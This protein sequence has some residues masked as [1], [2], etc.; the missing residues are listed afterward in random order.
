ME[1]QALTVFLIGLLFLFYSLSIKSK[2]LKTNKELEKQKALL[3]SKDRLLT[4]VSEA[5]NE[6]TRNFDFNRAIVNAFG[7]IGKVIDVDRIVL[8]ENKYDDAEGRLFA[9]YKGEWASSGLTAQ[10]DDAI[11]QDVPIYLYPDLIEPLKNKEPMIKNTKDIEPIFRK[12]LMEHSVYSIML[13]P[14]HIGDFF[15]GYVGFDDCKSERSWSESEKSILLSFAASIAGVIERNEKQQKLQESLSLIREKD[16]L[17]ELIMESTENGYILFGEQG[18]IILTNNM[19]F[20]MFDLPKEAKNVKFGSEMVNFVAEKMKDSQSF[21]DKT[22][23]VFKT[24]D[25]VKDIYEL[26]DNRIVERQTLPLYKDGSQ[27]GRLCYFRDI[28][29]SKVVE[30]MKNEFISTVNHELRTPLTSIQGSLGL[31]LSDS[32]GNIPQGVKE[33]MNIANNNCARLVNL[34]NDILDIE[35]IEAGKMDFKIESFAVLGL[36]E[37]AVEINTPYSKKFDV[38]LLIENVLS[39]VK[40]NVDKDRFLQVMTNLLSNAVKFSPTKSK[41]FVCVDKNDKNIRISVKDTG[42]G[43]PEEFKKHVFKKFSQSDSSDTRKKE[44]TG[45]GLSICKAIVEK[46]GGHIGFDSKINEGT[47]F[48]FEFPEYIEP[49]PLVT[50]SPT[51]LLK[52]PRILI[53]ED[54]RD[55]ASLIKMLFEQNGY[56]SHIAYNAEQAKQLLVQNT[57]DVITIDLILPDED[58]INLIKDIRENENTKNTPIIVVSIKAE[59]SSSELT[60][61]AAIIDWINKPIDHNKLLEALNR[62]VSSIISKPKILH[63]EDDDDILMVVSSILKDTAFVEQ[64]KSLEEAKDKLACNSFDIV[65]IDI[66]L[67]DG[68]GLDLLSFITDEHGKRDL[69]TLI[70]SAYEVDEKMAENVDMVLLK[71]KTSN[72][73]LL[74]AIKQLTKKV[75]IV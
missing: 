35:K 40:I 12:I 46:M 38:D 31:I 17:Q 16:M 8:W 47:T 22:K 30:R 13:F 32:F 26:K 73:K 33:L 52:Q 2:I 55:V 45:L 9:R 74:D 49:K 75:A 48:Y 18:E 69:L 23:A 58:G 14:I 60:C 10:I 5:I 36:V 41:V 64:A 54:D 15:W 4:A 6:L 37:Q 70:F 53:C 3:E 51:A 65:M 7:T 28:T 27:I 56:S 57:Y 11:L 44:G 62:A 63:V 67:P 29:Q 71:S 72:Q 42:T 50:T 43:I 19:F 21:I 34:I 66:E 20:K 25:N 1:N 39:D 61:D 24:L 59:E 68:N